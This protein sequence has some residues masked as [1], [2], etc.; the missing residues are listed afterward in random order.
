M[1]GD[2][3]KDLLH[4]EYQTGG[5]IITWR[6][7]QTSSRITLLESSTNRRV[8]QHQEIRQAD[9]IVYTPLR[10]KI[11]FLLTNTTTIML[12]LQLWRS[13]HSLRIFRRLSTSSIRLK[14]YNERI[15]ACRSAIDMTVATAIIGTAV[16]KKN[17]CL[18]Q[19]SWW[20][21]KSVSS[22]VSPH[23]RMVKISRHAQLQYVDHCVEVLV[24]VITTTILWNP[25]HNTQ[26]NKISRGGALT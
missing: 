9:K 23:K 6:L 5:G 8:V 21:I 12:A 4:E 16:T 19:S 10:V 11:M 17:Y 7:N 22:E 13:I 15:F 20:C 2:W 25:S 18:H 14:I 3:V 1:E 24:I 26:S